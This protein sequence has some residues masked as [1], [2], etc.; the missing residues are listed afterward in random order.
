MV[1]G[2]QTIHMQCV[3]YG[4]IT[5]TEEIMIQNGGMMEENWNRKGMNLELHNHFIQNNNSIQHYP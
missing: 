2:I 3:K 5:I 4:C 1:I